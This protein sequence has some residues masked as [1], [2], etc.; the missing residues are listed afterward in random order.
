MVDRFGGGSGR[1]GHLDHWK[2]RIED[3][4]G[5]D[6]PTFQYEGQHRF[7]DS[8]A[9]AKSLSY[10]GDRSTRPEGCLAVG[11][12]T[13]LEGTRSVSVE[14]GRVRGKEDPLRFSTYFIGIASREVTG[15]ILVVG[16]GALGSMLERIRV[17]FP[18]LPI[19]RRSRFKPMTVNGPDG[20]HSDWPG[21]QVRRLLES[22]DH[23]AVFSQ[24]GSIVRL[25]WPDDQ[26]TL[27]DLE[28]AAA[29]VLAAC[30]WRHASVYR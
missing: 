27:Q 9:Q 10:R 24:D 3:S 7:W 16:R 11:Q 12:I 2:H 25:E 6:P 8:F 20:P 13:P 23:A 17:V 18:F 4:L 15:K 5:P 26:P 1:Y 19:E 14:I 29:I 28:A 21:D 30:D 22:F